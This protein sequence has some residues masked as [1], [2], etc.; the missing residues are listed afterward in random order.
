DANRC[1][2]YLTIEHKGERPPLPSGWFGCD[3]CQKACPAT[4]SI[5]HPGHADFRA[6]QTLLTL[7]E[8]KILDMKQEEFKNTFGN[9]AILR[10]GLEGL[11]KNIQAQIL[12]S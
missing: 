5:A 12:R 4:H 8:E 3:R 10:A 9:S 6:S 7:T 1:L 2:S 11:Q